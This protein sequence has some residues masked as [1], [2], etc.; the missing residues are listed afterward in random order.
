M[1]TIQKFWDIKHALKLEDAKF[2]GY[3]ERGGYP[4]K[5]IK[6]SRYLLKKG[7][8]YQYILIIG[9]IERTPQHY[10]KE[11]KLDFVSGKYHMT[12]LWNN[13]KIS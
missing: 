8:P 1:P 10:P 6:I 4:G 7:L 3:W 13:Q 11:Y 5:G 12:N 2:E 9:N